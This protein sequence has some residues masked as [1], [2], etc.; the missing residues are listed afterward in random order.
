[1]RTTAISSLVALGI[2][3]AAYSYSNLGV[4]YAYHQNLPKSLEAF[5]KALDIQPTHGLAANGKRTIEIALEQGGYM[6]SKEAKD[7]TAGDII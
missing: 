6:L 7:I 5:N 3:A 2:G 4:G 1:M